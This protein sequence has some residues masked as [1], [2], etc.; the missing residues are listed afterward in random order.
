MQILAKNEV[1]RTEITDIN[2]MGY[3]IA[4]V[5]GIVVFVTHGVTGD[6]A[7]IKII[8]AASGY[9]IAVIVDLITPSPF[10]LKAPLCTAARRCGGCQYQHI[11]YAHECSLKQNYVRQALIKAG[12]P[13]I[14]VA[15][16]LTSGVTEGYRNKAQIPCGKDKQ[17]NLCAGY[18]APR[19]HQ[20]VPAENCLLQPPL[21]SEITAFIIDFAQKHGISAYSETEHTG[22]LRHIYIRG[23]RNGAAMV[24]L[25]LNGDAL[26]A[27]DELVQRLCCRFPMVTGILY[28]INRERTNVICGR[29]CRLLFGS[30]YLTDVL[31]GLTFRISPLAFYQV[32]H[33]A[34][35]L[36][37]QKAAEL[38]SLTGGE[39]LL[40]L[41]CGIGTIGLTMARRAGELIGIEVVEEAVKNARENAEING[42]SNASFYCGDTGSVLNTL[43]TRSPDAVVVDPPRKGLLPGA[44]KSLLD[45]SPEKLLY[46][47]CNPDTLARDIAHLEA[48]GYTCGP[49]TPVDLFPRTGH[50]E[51][52]VLLQRKAL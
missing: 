42:I 6:L 36:L 28:N 22:L 13:H 27:E 34:A 45:I 29:R 32:H 26:P 31:C 3:G 47:S 38:L 7:D 10:R 5:K 41:Y 48:S 20:I 19:S 35:E 46:I 8:K 25:V 14:P 21:F 43:A 49:V 40:D 17:G 11:T 2:N 30:P 23:A 12:L 4:R 39:T 1:Y 16:I 18:Y 15:D 24:C 44:L 37:Y 33:D 52:I 51:T 9:A 50:V